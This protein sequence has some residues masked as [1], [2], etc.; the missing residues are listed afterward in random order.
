MKIN[1]NLVMIGASFLLVADIFTEATE[2]AQEDGI[3]PCHSA[4][5]TRTLNRNASCESDAAFYN[6]AGLAFFKGKGFS[7]MLSN[8]T[9]YFYREHTLNYYAIDVEG[10]TPGA[11][12][13]A[14]TI[15]KGFRSNM[16]EKYTVETTAELFP[17]FYAIW[18]DANLAAFFSFNVLQASPS[19]VFEN[20]LAAVDYGLL[21]MMESMLKTSS[22]NDF[23]NFYRKETLIRDELYLGATVGF[24]HTIGKYLSLAFAFRYINA[25]GKM[26]VHVT[27]VAYYADY[28]SGPTMVTPDSSMNMDWNLETDTKGHGIGFIGGIHIKPLKNVNIGLRYEYYLP[29]KLKK[30]TMHFQ[31]PVL[32]E[33]SGQL[34]IFKDGKS[35]P[36]GVEYTSADSNGRSVLKV[37]YP[38]TLACGISTMLVKNLRAE[39]SGELIFRQFLDLDGVEN[40]YSTGYRAGGCLEWSI[41]PNCRISAGYVYNNTGIKPEARTEADPM[42][43]SHSVGGGFGFNINDHLDVS[44]GLYNMFFQSVTQYTKEETTVSGPTIHY[45]EKKYGERRF[46]IGIGITRRL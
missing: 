33:N 32:V 45:M 9:M 4:E 7:F 17:D 18:K 34:D 39:I 10:T 43:A 19:L 25:S 23:L 1:F 42:L 16:P 12:A 21:A 41:W 15:S 22:Y 6:P 35:S 30:T 5:Y 3:I 29:L 36:D 40:N 37:T 28:G 2:L 31:A 14:H 46:N 24:T 8:Q 38:Q 27:D 20:G 44:V 13:T 11:V 26:Q